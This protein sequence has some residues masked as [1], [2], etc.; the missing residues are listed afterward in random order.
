MMST[1]VYLALDYGA[2]RHAA[3][4]PPPAEKCP[5]GGQYARTTQPTATLSAMHPERH[6]RSNV[7]FSRQERRLS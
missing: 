3:A 1:R 4:W 7:D 2:A 6:G 5:L